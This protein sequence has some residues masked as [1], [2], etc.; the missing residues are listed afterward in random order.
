M[1]EHDFLAGYYNNR[2]E[3]NRLISK[4]G[5]VE[6]LTTMNYIRRYLT[7]SAKII[8]IGAGTGLY[9]RAIADMGYSVEAVELIQHNIDIFKTHMKPSQDINITLGNALGLSVFAD[10]SF[11]LTLSLGPMYHLYTDEDKKQAISEALRVT[12]SGGILFVAYCISDASIIRAG[13]VRK[14]FDIADYIKRGKI[15]PTTF[16][17]FSAEED[18]FELV[19]KEDIDR[20]MSSFN[21]E[22]LHYVATNLITHY[23]GDTIDEMDD[24]M[25]ALYLKYHMAIC[26]RADM[27][28][29]TNHSLDIFRKA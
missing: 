29:L 27:V 3:N 17:T 13:F 1:T 7:P 8:E 14:V 26:E 12:K 2:D 25:Y 16:E 5:Q 9:S 18:V 24:D 23:I 15:D 20:L 28:G 19:R 10:N 22:R 21:T 6:F 11:D 4:H